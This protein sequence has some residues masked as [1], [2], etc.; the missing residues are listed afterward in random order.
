MIPLDVPGNVTLSNDLMKN[1]KGNYSIIND[2]KAA[3]EC[4]Q[5]SGTLINDILKI[6]NKDAMQKALNNFKESSI[7]DANRANEHVSSTDLKSDKSNV[8]PR[9]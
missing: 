5:S 7:Y 6:T 3:N 8:K 1:G 9:N 2:I 4:Y